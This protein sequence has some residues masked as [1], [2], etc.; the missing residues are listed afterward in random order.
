MESLLIRVNIHDGVG[1]ISVQGDGFVNYEGF[2]LLPN[3]L[4]IL[5]EDRFLAPKGWWFSDYRAYL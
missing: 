2:L 3:A 1:F 5:N 4:A